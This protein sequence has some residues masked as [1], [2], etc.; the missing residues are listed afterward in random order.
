MTD[1][2]NLSSGG[3]RD[4]NFKKGYFLF[5]SLNVEQT[6][7]LIRNRPGYVFRIPLKFL[8]KNCFDFVRKIETV[9]IVYKNFVKKRAFL[10]FK[11][12]CEKFKTL[13]QKSPVLRFLGKF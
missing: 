12:Y 13:Y 9:R 4:K 2:K 11:G 3:G 7:S 5:G 8:K 1:K 10:V 6:K